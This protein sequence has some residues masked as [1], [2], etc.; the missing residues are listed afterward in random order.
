MDNDPP[1]PRRNPLRPTW[2]RE[3]ITLR[4][5]PSSEKITYSGNTSSNNSNPKRIESSVNLIPNQPC[6]NGDHIPISVVIDPGELLQA[7]VNTGS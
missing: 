7:D 4:F 5:V 1:P 6:A 3:L 2:K